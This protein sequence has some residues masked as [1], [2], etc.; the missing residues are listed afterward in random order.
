M[1]SGTAG[2]DI[3]IKRAW[4][5][6]KGVEDITIAIIDDGCVINHEDFDSELSE[7]PDGWDFI[8]PT[9]KYPVPDDDPQ[10][11][12]YEAHGTAC[13]GITSGTLS[14]DTGIAG[15]SPECWLLPL[16]C[17][18]DAGYNGYPT[19]YEDA[20]I[21]AVQ[22]GAQIVSCSWGW[23]SHHY[24]PEVVNAINTAVNWG[25]ICVFSAGND[26][27][28]VAFPANLS[29]TVAVGAIKRNGDHWPYSNSGQELDVVAPSGSIDVADADVHT[30][31]Q[32]DSLGYDPDW[33][34][35]DSVNE[36]YL[37]F[38]GGTSAACGG[39]RFS[40]RRAQLLPWQC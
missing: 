16:K 29:T 36:N 28:S 19:D 14:N 39:G 12:L 13:Q 7:E 22:H 20:I 6:T 24:Y 23:P 9:I 34:T 35:C 32:M 30:L 1:P 31:D 26:S 37:C 40:M 25:V 38:F 17:S 8:G 18:D 4:E 10:P 11:G 3:D 33:W 21:Y 2:I 15:V 5:I 27:G